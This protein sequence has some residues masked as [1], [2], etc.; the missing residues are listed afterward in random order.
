MR[1]LTPDRTDLI[2]ALVA[3]SRYPNISAGLLEKDEH[4]TDALGVIFQLPLKDMRL[5]FCGGSSLSKS[6]QLIERMSEDA[7]MKL[8]LSKTAADW[9]PSALRTKLSEAKK[10]IRTA[11]ADIDFVADKD[12][13]VALNGNKYFCSR[14]KYAA[15]YRSVAS[16]RPY[17]QVEFTVRTPVLKTTDLPLVRLTDRLAGQATD[18]AFLVPTVAVAETVA[19]KV[20]SFL[21]RF[22]QNRSGQMKQGWDIALVRH[23]YDVHCAYLNDN[24]VVKLAYGAFPELV[25]T[26]QKE[27]GSQFPEFKENA[28]SVLSDALS[29][30]EHDAQS[31]LEYNNNLLPLIYGDVRPQFSECFTSFKFVAESLLESL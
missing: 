23:L 8:V 14:W 16:L 5:V 20:L 25:S 22:A 30:I 17:L 28:K 26:D 12:K 3:D 29:K 7:D 11:L 24:A 19:E 13:D 9:T 18:T 6:H 31:Q 21:R 1:V 27:F 2:E 4:L 15:S 10:S